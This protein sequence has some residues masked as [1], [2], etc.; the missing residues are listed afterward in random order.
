MRDARV[1]RHSIP[2]TMNERGAKYFRAGGRKV[3]TDWAVPYAKLGDAILTARSIASSLDIPQ[4]V[5][6]GHAGNGHPHQNFIASNHDELATIEKAVEATLRHVISLG[7]TVAAEHGIGKIK[8][9]W[10]PL[11]MNALQIA[12]MAAVKRELDPDRLLAPGNI[13]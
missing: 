1:M 10:L 2:S 13:L 7:G 9:R 8:R 5:I 4:A 6:Y 11:Q 12:M 3:S